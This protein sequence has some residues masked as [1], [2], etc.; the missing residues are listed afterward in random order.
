MEFHKM[1]QKRGYPHV[2]RLPDSLDP[3]H[4]SRFNVVLRELNTARRLRALH[5]W[6]GSQVALS[7]MARSSNPDRGRV[8]ASG[9]WIQ[10]PDPHRIRIQG[11]VCRAQRMGVYLF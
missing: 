7:R 8:E 5:F 6:T 9:L 3:D 10:I 4:R 2:N 1:S 11:P